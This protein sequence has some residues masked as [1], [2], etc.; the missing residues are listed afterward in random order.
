[1]TSFEPA[2]TRVDDASDTK[3]LSFP[4]VV[5]Y[6][7]IFWVGGVWWR[8][9][10]LTT[11]GAC[12]QAF[13]AHLGQVTGLGTKFAFLVVSAC[14]AKVFPPRPAVTGTRSFLNMRT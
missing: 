5:D 14:R 1:M 7:W 9:P 8:S 2:E 13:W 3:V 12:A 11:K 4:P 10:V 6:S